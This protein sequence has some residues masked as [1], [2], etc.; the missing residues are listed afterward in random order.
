MKRKHFLYSAAILPVFGFAKPK[1]SIDEE[2]QSLVDKLKLVC[3]R[4]E[5]TRSGIGIRYEYYQVS[6]V[7][8]ILLNLHDCLHKKYPDLDSNLDVNSYWGDAGIYMFNKGI[9]PTPA[10]IWP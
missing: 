4:C 7:L 9:N 1:Q 5:L 10:D 2:I 8:P 3:E 6:K